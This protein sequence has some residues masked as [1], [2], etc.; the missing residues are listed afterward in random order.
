MAA[1]RVEVT[2]RHTKLDVQQ[3]VLSTNLMSSRIAAGQLAAR[4][5]A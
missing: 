3:F 2:S 5:G 1:Q 4:C